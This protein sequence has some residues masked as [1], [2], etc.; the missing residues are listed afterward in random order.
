MHPNPRYRGLKPHPEAL[1][2]L[3]PLKAGEASRPVRVR[4]RVE[5]FDWLKTMNATGIG[6]VLT[7]AYEEAQRQAAASQAAQLPD[8]PTVRLVPG[9]FEPTKPKHRAILDQ[10]HGG[11]VLTQQGDAFVLRL[12]DGIEQAV[13]PKTGHFL[14]RSGAVIPVATDQAGARSSQ[15]PELPPA[16]RRETSKAPGR[17]KA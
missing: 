1:G 6:L 12:S 11:G 5:V 15:R 10:L 9:M 7:A 14:V 2:I 4:A 8:V 16:R 13:H 17:R 3:E